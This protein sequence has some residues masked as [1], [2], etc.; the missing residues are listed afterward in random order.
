METAYDRVYLDL[1]QNLETEDDLKQVI[2]ALTHFSV[3]TFV[4]ILSC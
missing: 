2:E 4:D 3:G 1:V